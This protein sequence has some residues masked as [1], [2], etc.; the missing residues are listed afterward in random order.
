MNDADLYHDLRKSVVVLLQVID[1]INGKDFDV[2]KS[3]RT[4]LLVSNLNTLEKT[5][6][7]RSL[8]WLKS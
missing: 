8:L 1:Q 3:K 4:R 5:V 6:G 2:Y 7:T